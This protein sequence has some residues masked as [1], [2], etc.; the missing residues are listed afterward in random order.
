M[1]GLFKHEKGFVKYCTTDQNGE[2]EWYR[3]CE[4]FFIA[5]KTKDL[6]QNILFEEPAET[7]ETLHLVLL[8]TSLT[9]FVFSR[10]LA[11]E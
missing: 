9:F 8:I 6:F 3:L 2:M 4:D 5:K 7:I 10:R 11:I 1:A